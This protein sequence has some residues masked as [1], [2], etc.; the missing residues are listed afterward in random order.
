MKKIIDWF[1]PF[2][3]YFLVIWIALII[4]FSSLPRLPEIK[5]EGH[6]FEIRLDY[7]IHFVEYFTLAFLSLLTF[8][9]AGHN[10]RINRVVA[11]FF[12]LMLF[13]AI[14]ETHQ[15]LIPGRSFNPLDMLFNFTGI[16]GGSIFTLYLTDPRT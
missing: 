4:V 1:R 9:R 2:A 7:L 6:S 13:A 15:L 12:L 14:D 16:I 10:K 5:I 8:D 11:I 3:K